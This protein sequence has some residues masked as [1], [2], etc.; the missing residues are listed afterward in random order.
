MLV[1][2]GA[3]LLCRKSAHRDQPVLRPHVLRKISRLRITTTLVLCIFL[4]PIL[5]ACSFGNSGSASSGNAPP[6]T[7]SISASGGTTANPD[8]SAMDTFRL[9][10]PPEGLKLTPLFTQPAGDDD[11]RF[12]RLEDAVQDLRN[13]F[14]TVLP[15]LVRLVAV[16]KDMKD[17]IDQLKSLSEDPE[18]YTSP[19]PPIPSDSLPAIENSGQVDIPGEDAVESVKASQ[20]PETESTAPSSPVTPEAAPHEEVTSSQG[21][22]SPSSPPPAAPSGS[23]LG[24]VSGIRVGDHADKTRIVLDMTSEIDFT[25]NLTNGDRTL[26]VDLPRMDMTRLNTA[27]PGSDDLVS[28]YRLETNRL[29]IDLKYPASVLAQDLLMPDG[30]PYYRLVIDLTRKQAN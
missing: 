28:G 3:S 10:A 14:D 11:A 18:A 19:P 27:P 2:L 22:A 9:L 12:E 15:S 24:A 7:E 26:A 21:A 23:F 17:L 20:T 8:P 5:S 16:E 25:I 30:S 29:L 4:L 6:P 13:D 1:N